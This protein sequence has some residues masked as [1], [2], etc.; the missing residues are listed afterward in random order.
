M[1]GRLPCTAPKAHRAAKDRITYNDVAANWKTQAKI[2]EVKNG[3]F[4][5][6]P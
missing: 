4:A 5:W 1:A 6:K 3:I 2:L